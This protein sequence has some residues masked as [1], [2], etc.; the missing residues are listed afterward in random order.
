MGNRYGGTEHVRE[1]CKQLLPLTNHVFGEPEG[2]YRTRTKSALKMQGVF[3][4]DTVLPPQEQ[5]DPK[6]REEFR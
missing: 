4:H 1:I 6:E 5:I 3:E 2:R